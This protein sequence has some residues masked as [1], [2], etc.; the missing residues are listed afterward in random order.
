MGLLPAVSPLLPLLGFLK[1]KKE[2][3]ERKGFAKGAESRQEEV[4]QQKNVAE[5][6][7]LKR[8]RRLQGDTSQ[9]ALTQQ[10][11]GRKTLL[12]Q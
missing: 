1:S 11:T 8:L 5:D 9:S 12:G 2:G 10:A 4:N 6:Q 3:A 7:R